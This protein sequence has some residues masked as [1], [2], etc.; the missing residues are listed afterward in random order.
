MAR[1]FVYLAAVVDWFSRRVLAWRLSIE[2]PDIHFATIKNSLSKARKQLPEGQPGI[3]FVKLPAQWV[4]QPNFA[5]PSI[6][7]AERFAKSSDRVASVVY[8]AAPFHFVDGKLGQG[9]LFKEVPNPKNPFDVRH[10]WDLL[11]NWVPRGDGWNRMPPKWV[12]LVFF[13]SKEPP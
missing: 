5:K 8:C 9:H 6:I 4:L 7:L 3:I 13:P 11:N 10:K 12:R 1:G 2:T